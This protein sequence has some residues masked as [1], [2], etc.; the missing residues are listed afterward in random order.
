M[1]P[2]NLTVWVFKGQVQP[3]DGRMR[4]GRLGFETGVYEGSG[5]QRLSA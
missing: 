3:G 2:C 4:K 5:E 1:V